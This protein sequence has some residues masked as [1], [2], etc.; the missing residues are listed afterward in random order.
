MTAKEIEVR[1]LRNFQVFKIPLLLH[2]HLVSQETNSKETTQMLSGSFP[3]TGISGM[4]F[5]NRDLGI[6][7]SSSP[8]FCYNFVN[9]FSHYVIPNVHF[10]VKANH[11]FCVPFVFVS[12]ISYT[13]LINIYHSGTAIVK[14]RTFTLALLFWGANAQLH[15]RKIGSELCREPP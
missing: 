2:A 9:C 15:Q 3:S 1:N 8:S 12:I 14:M 11:Y 13:F 10:F 5:Q 7:R 4:H 6:F